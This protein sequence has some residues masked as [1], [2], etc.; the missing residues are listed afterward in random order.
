MPARSFSFFDHLT[1]PVIVLRK[2][3]TVGYQNPAAVEFFG[4]SRLNWQ[5]KDV[6]DS[7]LLL[8]GIDDGVGTVEVD[9]DSYAAQITTVSGMR[10]VIIHPRDMEE[11]RRRENR[12]GLIRSAE[13]EMRNALATSEMAEENISR[14]AAE[15]GDI[16]LIRYSAA[17]CHAWH[18]MLR[19]VEHI[20]DFLDP[21]SDEEA[22][23]MSPFDIRERCFELVS[24]VSYL[25]AERGVSI[26]VK[27]EESQINILGNRRMLD[28]MILNLLS[29][30][31]KNTEPGGKITV[32][33]K[34]AKKSL[35]IEVADTGSG[36]CAEKA[37]E[38]F[39]PLD[40]R[41]DVREA[42]EGLGLGLYLVHKAAKLHGGGVAIETKEGAGTKV[43]IL[44]KNVLDESVLSM[45][46]EGTEPDVDI[47]FTELA[48]IL[49]TK[50]YQSERE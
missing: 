12:L 43:T 45:P 39:R 48:D 28:K 41:R 20:S 3:G 47:V 37:A 38:L 40:S 4:D 10:A 18:G 29:N 9:G 15:L 42:D 6:L 33:L 35:L 7:T 1:E 46:S 13:R 44:V 8:L 14:R 24:A 30:S 25:A 23:M 17:L 32:T 49:P 27:S 31:L 22:V 16:S 26:E 34:R 19:V 5:V 11:H 21:E 2:D 50:A 36:I